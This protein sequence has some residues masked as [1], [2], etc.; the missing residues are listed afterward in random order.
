M[1]V[2]VL[3]G[4]GLLGYH[5]VLALLTE[6]HQV[7]VVSRG[8]I[9][10]SGLFP[11]GVSSIETDLF[12][13]D[14][15]RLNS[16]FEPFDALV[17]ALGPDDRDVPTRPASPFFH[18]RLV[19][20]CQSI[21]QCAKAS[22]V[23]KIVIMGSY[24][25]YFDRQFPGWRLAEKHPYIHSR[26]AQSSACLSLGD[27]SVHVSI[28]E[29]PYVFGI[30]PGREPLWKDLLIRRISWMWPYIYFTDGGTVMMTCTQLGKAVV[31]PSTLLP[32]NDI[33]WVTP[34]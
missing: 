32:R 14:T 10:Q 19:V 4:T 16:L 26:V 6:N 22:G 9:R 13:L 33:P 31:G 23:R 21:C 28:L 18:N 15:D 5:S 8:S 29:I 3:G 1:K 20:K 11:A 34:I 7:T 30:M 25:S 2:I 12:E 27:P 24:F 17:Y